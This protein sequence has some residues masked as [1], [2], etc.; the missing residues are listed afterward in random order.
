MYIEKFD[1]FRI[2]KKFCLLIL[3]FVVTG[4]ASRKEIDES[5]VSE[6]LYQ[7]AHVQYYYSVR[8]TGNW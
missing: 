5:P 8:N 3:T 4:N 2:R 6:V 1:L 7:V